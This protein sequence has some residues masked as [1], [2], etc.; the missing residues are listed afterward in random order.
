MRQGYSNWVAAYGKTP[1]NL[2]IHALKNL[3]QKSIQRGVLKAVNQKRA[4][5]GFP[6]NLEE[7]LSLCSISPEDLGAPSFEEAYQEA[8]NGGRDVLQECQGGYNQTVGKDWRH[9][10]IYHAY[11]SIDGFRYIDNE[12]T[13]RERFAKKYSEMIERI[14]GGEKLE[15]PEVVLRLNNNPSGVKTSGN[16]SLAK[17]T[18]ADLKSM[19]KGK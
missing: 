9:P 18:L 10:A 12:K 4:R 1:N 19:F 5:N 17:S 7:F 13:K 6:P 14:A 3:D 8:C 16:S 2:W 15:K 11:R